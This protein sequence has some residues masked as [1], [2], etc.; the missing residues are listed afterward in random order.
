MTSV[1]V[2]IPVLDRP[3]NVEPLLVSLIASQRETPL[4]PLF[5]LTPGY[6]AELDAVRASGEDYAV[7]GFELGRGDYARKI[8]L[9]AE[10]ADDEWLLMAADDLRFEPGWADEALRVAARTGARVIGTQDAG[11]PAV[12]RGV[13]ATHILFARSYVDELGTI[14]EPG[15]ALHEGYWHWFCDNEAV[16]TAKTRREWAFAPNAVVEHLHPL[17]GKGADDWVYARGQEHA[18]KDKRLLLARRPLWRRGA[19]ARRLAR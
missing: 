19:H 1:C 15:K 3:A 16:E 14:D 13:H 9:A 18:E 2:A 8:N 5:V 7:A 17:W 12:K 11:N 10:V 6:E 4:W